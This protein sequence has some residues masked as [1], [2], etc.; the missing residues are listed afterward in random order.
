MSVFLPMISNDYY[1]IL[2][3]QIK[4]FVYILVLLYIKM[5]NVI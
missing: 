2:F 1:Q 5:K 4:I 3:F